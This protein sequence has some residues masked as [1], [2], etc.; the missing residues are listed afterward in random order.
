MKRIITF[1]LFVLFAVS[2]QSQAQFNEGF[3]SGTFPPANWTVIN[4]GDSNGWEASTTAHTGSGAAQISY[5]SDAHDDW[6]ITPAITVV[7]GSTDR[8]TFWAKNSSSSWLEQFNVKLSTTGT[9]KADFTVDLDNN[10]EPPTTYTQYEYDISTYVGQT[11]YIAIQ[12]IS[13]NQF[14]LYIDDVVNDAMPACPNPSALVAS[15]VVTDSADL[16]WTAG[17]S[18]SAWNIEYGPAGFTPGSGTTVAA[19]TNPYNLTG[20]TSNTAYDFYVQADCA[21]GGGTGTSAWVG[22]YSFTTSPG[23]GDTFYDDGGATG[24]Y[25]AHL[26]QII[27]IYPDNAGDVVTVTFNSFDME[28]NY[29]KMWVYNGPDVNA[30]VISSGNS[31]DS[32]TGAPGDSYTAD[33]QSFTS[34]DATGAL[35]FEFTSDSSVQHD[36]WEAVVS[37]GP[38]PACPNPSALVA[39]NVVTDS[40]DLSWT[41]GGSESAWNIEYGPAGF[42]PGSG[43]TVA[44][45]TNPY[46]LTG[47]T[48]NT[49]YDFYVQADCA[50]GGGTGTSAWVGPYSFTTSPGCGDTFY[51]DGGPSGDYTNNMNQTLTI[52]PDNPGDLVTVTFNMFDME[53]NWDKMWVYDGPDTNS[54]VISSGNGDDSWT[55]APGDPYT[56][57]GQSFTSTHATGALTFVFTSDVSVAHAGWEAVIT[58]SP[59]PTCDAPSNLSGSNVTSD[60]VDLTWTEN[61]SATAWNIEYGPAGFTQGQGTVVAVTTNPYTLTGLNSATSYD[62]YVQSDCGGGDTS[63]WEGP[64]SFTTTGTCG[65]FTVDLID[66]YGD[67]WNGG[68]LTVYINGTPFLTGITLD[69]GT[70]P[71]SHYIPVNSG[72]ILSFEYTAGSWSDENEYIV[73]DN[74]G[75]MVADEGTNGTPGSIGDP[76][77]PSG[78]QA[79]PTC[80]APSNLF[81]S[82]IT[83]FT[84]DLSW[85]ENGTATAWNI[86]Y[87]PAGFMQGQGTVV[88]ASTN[89][90]TLTGLTASTDYEFYVQSDCG[91]GDISTW[92]GPYTFKT[93]C[94]TQ[95]PYIQDFDSGYDC[96]TIE[97]TNGDGRTWDHGTSATSLSCVSGNGDYVMFAKFNSGQDMNDWLFSPGF[98]LTAGVDYTIL[99]SYGND[100]TSNLVEDMDVYIS[101]GSNSYDAVNGTQI[102]S[103]TGIAD[104]CH[105]FSNS[106]ITVPT[107]GIYYVAFHGK[108]PAGQDILMIDDFVIDT[109]SAVDELTNVTGIYPNPT[110]GDFVIKSHDLNDA[111]VFIYSMSGQEIYHRTIDSDNYTINLNNVKK[112]VYFVKVTSDNKS[113]T[114]K[115]IIK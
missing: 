68:S 109:T 92:A 82:N 80:P 115:L 37:C 67:G 74:N 75:V 66:S 47:L 70:G 43:T 89:P 99:F 76:S 39:S 6:L 94:D 48:S 23:C 85:T 56:A 46:N 58:C 81:A 41:A 54:P 13:T 87:G 28:Q 88:P 90:Y 30:P 17:G 5:S 77:V 96:W 106:S 101:T 51:D 20:L 44:A 55:G 86:E 11:V 12:A 83:P 78:L 35:T 45:T 100:G 49:A 24:P 103:E 22:P 8:L 31:D 57:D 62:V 79:C 91:G 113:Y 1:L 4:D 42:T 52:Y 34:T 38:P 16:S 10:V 53:E 59:P 64:Y 26:N 27:T 32:W 7:S 9:A 19:T 73:Y 25:S 61:G 65:T 84:A 2:W 3:E 29:D 97:D 108:S 105:S 15:N 18:E 112:G 14:R 104:G 98:Y 36:G 71:E 95:L 50:A 33:G 114:S 72:D 69:T 111:K 102:L 60:S 93:L 21:A 63:T 110:T 107:D 40:A